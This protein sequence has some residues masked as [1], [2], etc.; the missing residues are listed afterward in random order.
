LANH[1]EGVRLAFDVGKV[2]VGV[3]VS[4]RY[5]ILASPLV[6]LKRLDTGL[7]DAVLN[8][9]AENEPVEIFVGLPSSL[10]NQTTESTLDALIFARFLKEIVAVPIWLVDERLSTVTAAANLRASGRS[11]MTS[12]SVIDQQAAC[13]ILDSALRAIKN[14]QKVGV[15]VD[16]YQNES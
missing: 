11:A 1:L 13:V 15:N 7:S 4:D 8:I 2:N 12:K 10:K 9:C 3:A 14:G 5:G 16:E 6:T